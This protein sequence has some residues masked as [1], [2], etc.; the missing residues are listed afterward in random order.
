MQIFK[1]TGKIIGYWDEGR[2]GLPPFGCETGLEGQL[3][4]TLK[5]M[6]WE[7]S[8]HKTDS[9]GGGGVAVTS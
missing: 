9:G 3:H 5:P 7:N 4:Y 6:K 1:R 8:H 2:H